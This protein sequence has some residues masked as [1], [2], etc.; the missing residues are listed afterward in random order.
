[1]VSILKLW[2][3]N[4]WRSSRGAEGY[5]FDHSS[6]CHCRGTSLIPG[7]AHWVKDPT[8]LQMWYRSQLQLGFN[9]WPGNIFLEGYIPPKKRKER[10]KC[11][12]ACSGLILENNLYFSLLFLFIGFGR[13][14]IK[15]MWSNGNIHGGKWTIIYLSKACRTFTSESSSF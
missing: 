4:T 8:L 11:L 2:L 6:L 12:K 1:M 15:G 9:P 5:G 13:A 3:K 10:K 7:F 14:V